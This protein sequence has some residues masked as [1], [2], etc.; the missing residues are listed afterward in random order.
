MAAGAQLADREDEADR[1]EDEQG[2]EVLQVEAFQKYGV[3][4]VEEV[5]G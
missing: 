1:E 5:W 2:N 4:L 3:K